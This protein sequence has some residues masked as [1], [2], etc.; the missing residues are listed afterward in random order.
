MRL[1]SILVTVSVFLLLGAC[2][3]TDFGMNNGDDKREVINKGTSIVPIPLKNGST[4]RG[5]MSARDREIELRRRAEM[6]AARRE[7]ESEYETPK[8]PPKPSRYVPTGEHKKWSGEYLIE[9]DELAKKG[10]YKGATKK[11]RDAEQLWPDNPDFENRSVTFFIEGEKFYQKENFE[12][13]L[14]R[15]KLAR[16]LQPK[17]S[18]AATRRLYH[19][20]AYISEKKKKPGKPDD[21]EPDTPPIKLTPEEMKKAKRLEEIKKAFTEGETFL[22]EEE[23]LK[24]LKKF[25]EVEELIKWFPHKVDDA[26]YLGRSRKHRKTCEDKLVGEKKPKDKPEDKSKDKKENK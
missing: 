12:E 22:K 2:S 24:A 10:D 21:K 13:A 14:K 23:H 8:P 9:G 20:M 3:S 6:E 11:Y 5:G 15:Y 25:E 17:K 16:A 4:V 7:R 18:K 26:D 19:C 1:F